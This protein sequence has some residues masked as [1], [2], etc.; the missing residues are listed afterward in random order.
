MHYKFA[1]LALR[2]AYYS[3]LNAIYQKHFKAAS[4]GQTDLNSALRAAEEE[5]V[6]AIAE[7]KNK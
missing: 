2:P 4:L 3:Q 1:P 5:S 7:F 6:K